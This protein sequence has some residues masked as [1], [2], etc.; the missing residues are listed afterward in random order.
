LAK[1]KKYNHIKSKEDES[2][3][4]F[5]ELVPISEFK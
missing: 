2:V 3:L 5:G 1:H 4:L